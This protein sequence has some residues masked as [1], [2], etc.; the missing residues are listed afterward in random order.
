MQP[1]ESAMFPARTETSSQARA[2]I[3]R[4]AA[5][6][7]S[8]RDFSAAPDDLIAEY[9]GALTAFVPHDKMHLFHIGKGNY[10]GDTTHPGAYFPGGAFRRLVERARVDFDALLLERQQQTP[11]R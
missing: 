10:V 11:R 7:I 3:D 4:L 5:E 2:T 6:T 8:F 1:K 9:N